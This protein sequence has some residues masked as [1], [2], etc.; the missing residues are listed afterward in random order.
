MYTN[1][2]HNLCVLEYYISLEYHILAHGCSILDISTNMHQVY[3]TY[4]WT[5]QHITGLISR[6][7]YS[8]VY[9]SHCISLLHDRTLMSTFLTAFIPCTP[10]THCVDIVTW[11]SRIRHVYSWYINSYILYYLIYISIQKVYYVYNLTYTYT[12]L[13]YMIAICINLL[14]KHSVYNMYTSGFIFLGC[15]Y[16]HP[17]FTLLKHCTFL[18]S[19]SLADAC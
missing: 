16:D 12:P 8:E 9:S 6:G 4:W 17:T 2:I 7:W 10:C 14:G 15:L 1:C 5:F 13:H 18:L 19:Q 11:V 3:L